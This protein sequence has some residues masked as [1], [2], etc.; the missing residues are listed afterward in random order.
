MKILILGSISRSLLN[1]RGPLIQRLREQGHTVITATASD[2]NFSQV[3][4]I[5]KTWGVEYRTVDI[6]R[7]GTNP[8]ADTRTRI[9]IH[10]LLGD[11]RPDILLAYTAKP[12]IYGGMA[13]QL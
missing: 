2:E 5:L 3:A 11:S 6:A 7:G 12:V 13:D 9:A 8:L 1:F 10:G 4:E